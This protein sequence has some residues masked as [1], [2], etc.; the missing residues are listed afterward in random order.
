MENIKQYIIDF[1][2]GRADADQFMN[3]CETD[4]TI[5]DWVQ[6]LVPEGKMLKLID[7]HTFENGKFKAIIREEWKKITYN[8][9]N[10]AAS[11]LN[12]QCLLY[13]ML[14][15]AFP[16]EEITFNEYLHKKHLLILDVCPF[17]ICGRQAE[18]LVEKIIDENPKA[19]K[20][21]LKEMVRK[22]FH[23]EGRK[24][25]RWAQDSDWPFSESGKP[26]KYISQRNVDS[27]TIELTFEDVDTG[28]RS[29]VIDIY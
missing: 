13:E 15:E 19:S 4:P 3:D 11:K 18:A 22:S 21:T 23:I 28:K 27:E 20:K 8:D 14:K 26:M 7:G 9:S 1:I 17:Y 24:Y 12:V 5:L 10:R 16:E 6:T 25:P 2:E 29:T